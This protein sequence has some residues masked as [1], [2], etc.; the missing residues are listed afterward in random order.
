MQVYR[1][2]EIGNAPQEAGIYAWY[3]TPELT[4]FDIDRVIKEANKHKAGGDEEA[5][6]SVLT[7]FLSTQVFQYFVEQPYTAALYGPLKPRY[8][9]MLQH[10]PAL[11]STLIQRL[12]ENP[13]RLK[14]I[15]RILEAAV[16]NFS[17]PI[18]I[19]MSKMLSWRLSRHKALIEKYL[20]TPGLIPR[21]EDLDEDE[22]RDHSFAKEVCTRRIPAAR[23][24]VMVQVVSGVADE[25][26]DIEN[27]LNRIHFPLL[28]RN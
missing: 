26:I 24:S 17:S 27:I 14:T 25:W 11:S 5:A 15:K 19:G 23:L 16:P 8:E 13:E 18:Y 12:I 4:D 3:F 6:L 9:G 22:R 2:R 7:E 21:L 10:K 28:G 1:W 20:E